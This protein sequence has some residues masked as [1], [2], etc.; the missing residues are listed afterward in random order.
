MQIKYV[1]TV[2]T[3]DIQEDPE[4]N[5]Y[6]RDALRAQLISMG[7]EDG[8]N[9]STMVHKSRIPKRTLD[10]INAL[11]NVV[12][13]N[14]GDEISIYTADLIEKGFP[15]VMVKRRYLYSIH[16]NKFQ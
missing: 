10:E 9:Q 15:P 7:Y 13:F 2:I 14:R 1:K 3:Y 12:K 5:G 6:A 8:D 4:Y 11:C 16:A